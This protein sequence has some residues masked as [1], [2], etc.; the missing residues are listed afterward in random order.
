MTVLDILGV[1]NL[2]MTRQFIPW[3]ILSQQCHLDLWPHTWIFKVKFWN[4]HISRT[5]GPIDIEQKYVSRSFMTM[6]CMGGGGGDFRC[7]HANS[8]KITPEKMDWS[9]VNRSLIP[10]DVTWPQWFDGSV[11]SSVILFI[12]IWNIGW[13]NTQCRAISWPLDAVLLFL[14]PRQLLW[15][16]N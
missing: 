13:S 14:N 1:W 4:S 8:V 12:V 10:Y 7:W 2:F 9:S 3:Y 6:T 15:D 11:S 16:W 5:G